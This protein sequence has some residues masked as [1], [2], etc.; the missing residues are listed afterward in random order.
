MSNRLVIAGAGGFGRELVW[1]VESSPKFMGTN[2]I[3]EVVLIDDNWSRTSLQSNVVGPVSGYFPEESDVVLVAIGDPLGRKSV[4]DLLRSRG[5]NF[6]TFRHDQSVIGQRV[7]LSQGSIICLD[8]RVTVDCHVG[9]FVVVN[10]NTSIGHDVF[11][12]DFVTIG[13]G[14]NLTG[15]VRVESKASIGAGAVLN[16]GIVVA[17]NAR[18]AS[19]S[20]VIK[21]VP[22]GTLV[23]GSPAHEVWSR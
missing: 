11:I 18:V 14:C 17:Q 21:D 13:P 23:A 5:A 12:G 15:R 22:A 7:M 3:S 10:V 19:G 9:E 1:Q 16:P 6:T 2:S 4:S 20:T 8:A